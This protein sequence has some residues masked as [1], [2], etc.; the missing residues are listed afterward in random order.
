MVFEKSG[1]REEILIAEDSPT[2]AEMLKFLLENENFRVTVAHNGR[3]A[4]DLLM[5]DYRPIIVIS[6]IVMPEMDGYALCSSIKRNKELKDIPVILLTVLS[7]PI[8]I[9]NGLECGAD[10]FIT[11][12]YEE[13]YLITRIRYVLANRVRHDGENEQAGIKI[14]FGGKDYH[15]TANRQ[16]ILNLLLSTYETAVQKNAEL[17][18]TQQELETLNEQ[19]EKKVEERTKVLETQT[20]KRWLAEDEV[21]R[22]NSE[23]KKQVIESTARLEATNKEL[24]AISKSLLEEYTDKLDDPGKDYLRRLRAAIM[25]MEQ[26]INAM[27]IYDM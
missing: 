4:L 13:K 19:L 5:N 10:N 12:P 6:D 14:S 26:L 15:I 18:R 21:S 22:L 1:N 9:L 8:D 25:R 3:E 11:K 20:V 27:K 16:Q 17:Q 7:D 24:D 23:L 2:Q